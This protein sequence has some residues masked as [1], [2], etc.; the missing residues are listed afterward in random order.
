VFDPVVEASPLEGVV[1]VAGAIRGQHDEWRLLGPKR[2]EL[3]DRHR[4]VG[5]DLEKECLEF[6]VG[7]VDFVNDQHR[8]SE[9][10]RRGMMARRSGRRTKNR[11]ENNSS[12]TVRTSSG[13]PAC[14]AAEFGG[15][16]MEQLSGEVPLVDRLADVDSLVALETNQLPAGPSGQGVRHLGLPAA[17]LT[18]QEERTTEHHGQEDRRGQTVVGEVSVPSRPPHIVGR[19][20]GVKRP[21]HCP[22]H[23][24]GHLRRTA[25]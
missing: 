7:P 14:R 13:P 23:V 22:G 15:P 20:W 12:S 25:A 24:I 4:V 21:A 1:H 3:G 2:P 17:G 5:Q 6:V 11:S 8:R 9:A 10:F 18:F 16:Q 19:L